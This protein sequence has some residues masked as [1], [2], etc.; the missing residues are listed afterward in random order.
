[1]GF[2]NYIVMNKGVVDNIVIC[3]FNIDYGKGL[4]NCV[5]GKM[6]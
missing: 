2:I 3:I 1:M 5:W 6:L 4:C